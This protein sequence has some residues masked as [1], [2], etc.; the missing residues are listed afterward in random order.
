MPSRGNPIKNRLQR[1]APSPKMSHFWDPIL[2]RVAV[3]R[4]SSCLSIFLFFKVALRRLILG[5][6]ILAFSA[7][8][9]IGEHRAY[10]SR[11]DIDREE[12][13]DFFY[14]GSFRGTME[15]LFRTER[16]C[17]VGDKTGA[18]FVF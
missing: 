12:V 15:D 18:S 14:G 13:V 16:H 17:N 3:P 8:I 4:I 2:R 1:R 6:L 11:L 5:R 10:I 7:R 9:Y